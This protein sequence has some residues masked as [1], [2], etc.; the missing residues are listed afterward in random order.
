MK[1]FPS[2]HK[3]K[4][5]TESHVDL[6]LNIPLA[7]IELDYSKYKIDKTMRDIAN[8]DI[9]TEV[10]IN[11][12]FDS[13]AVKLFNKFGE[14]V[15]MDNLLTRVGSKYY[16]KPKDM[17]SFEPQRFNYSVTIKTNRPYKI[18][19][20]YNINI[21]CID[22]PDSLDLSKRIAMGFSNPAAREIVPPNISI[23]NDRTDAYAFTDMNIDMCD[24]L[25]IE[26]P[27]GIHYDDSQN[28][29][30]IDKSIFLNKN[31][32]VWTASDFDLNYPYENN[33]IA[34]EYKLKTPILNSKVTMLSDM[35]FNPSAMPYN[36]NVVYHNIFEGNYCPILIIEHLGKGYEI[37]SHSGI[38]NNI[39]DN[40][41]IMYEMIMYCYLNTY[42]ST[43][44][45]SQWIAS[46][47]PD[48]QI[49]SN[50][51]VKKKYFVSDIDLY[52][53]FNLK[54]NE[55]ILYDVSITG[56]NSANTPD[57]N[58]VDLFDY[59]STIMFVGMAG[60][61]LMFDKTNSPDS[62]YN[63]E[64]EKPVGWVSIYDG[65]NIIY[66]RELHYSIETDLTNRVFTTVRDNDL[67]VKILAFKST[68]LGVDTQMPFDKIIPF[69]KTE[70]NKIEM[71]READYIFYINIENQEIGYDF[72]EDYTEDKGIALFDIRVYQ[73]PDSIHVTD[74]RQLGGGLPEDMPDNYNLL[75]IGH[76][77][78][79]PYRPSGTL[80]FTLPTKYKEHQELIEKAINKYIG[81]SEVPVIFFEDTEVPEI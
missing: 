25:F 72:I 13:P 69:I 26:S 29:I 1:I 46:Q 53:Y 64:P 40:I 11:Q 75:D 37:I 76:I 18:A 54:A 59:A 12:E 43:G 52:K 23:N 77:N 28:P 47:V 79:R 51:L 49:E 2:T 39:Q 38:L 44:Q 6:D 36:P 5:V 32:T 24:I 74:M 3:I 42:K 57:D 10:L 14:A 22:D 58:N 45:L 34:V 35:Y 68:S 66:L 19:N 9:K 56:E 4:S 63:T 81:A 41:Q 80:V 50:K 20:K 27:D 73:T 21:A 30:K 62:S 15:N 33:E 31:T 48:Y 60:G 67:A 7:Y 70:V 65:S 61:R 78:G 55:L 16:Y 71:I 8:T 17:I